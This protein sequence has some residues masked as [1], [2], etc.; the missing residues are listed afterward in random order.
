MNRLPFVFLFLIFGCS[1]DLPV[2]AGSTRWKMAWTVGEDEVV[3]QLILFN[4]SSASMQVYG[5]PGSLLVRE[6]EQVRL[7]WSMAD[8][9]LQLKR[10][11]NQVELNYK[12]LE[13]N[14][15][16]IKMSFAE[17]IIVSLLRE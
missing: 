9:Y 10:M 16:H 12:I 3:G 11:D 15:S 8:D 4:D 7:H 2:E 1:E 17:D 5:N 6:S 13:K 14:P